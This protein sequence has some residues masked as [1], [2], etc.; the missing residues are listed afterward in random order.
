VHWSHGNVGRGFASLGLRLGA[1]LTLGLAFGGSCEETPY[2]HGTCIDDFVVGFLVGVGSAVLLDAFALS[3]EKQPRK[4]SSASVGKLA[5][6]PA[7]SRDG[8]SGMVMA[9]GTF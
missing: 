4:G 3:W 2:S 9:T 6:T 7:V 1:P 8:Q 5:L